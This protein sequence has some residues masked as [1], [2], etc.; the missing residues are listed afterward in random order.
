MHDSTRRGEFSRTTLVSDKSCFYGFEKCCLPPKII[1]YVV[2]IIVIIHF[3]S[4]VDCDTIPKRPRKEPR[5]VGGPVVAQGR[6]GQRVGGLHRAGE[7][8]IEFLSPYLPQGTY[9]SPLI[10]CVLHSW[11]WGRLFSL[12]VKLH[13]KRLAAFARR[14]ARASKRKWALKYDRLYFSGRV[15]VFDEERNRVVPTRKL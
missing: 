7:T 2:L 12:K 8:L 14:R 3:S 13:R 11:A 5:A 10:S 15:F 1:F 6:S 4:E 9:P